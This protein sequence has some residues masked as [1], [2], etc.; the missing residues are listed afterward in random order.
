MFHGIQFDGIKKIVNVATLWTQSQV[1]FK[2][3]R[4]VDVVSTVN[5]PYNY[6]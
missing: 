4:V 6:G 1:L 2:V 3:F 5:S